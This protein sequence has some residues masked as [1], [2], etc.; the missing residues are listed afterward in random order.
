[1]KKY[2]SVV[3][4]LVLVAISTVGY[5]AEQEKRVLDKEKVVEFGL[6]KSKKL[7]KL[8]QDIKIAQAKL[9]GAESA[10][11]PN[12]DLNTNYTR[13]GEAPKTNGSKDKFSFK[14]NLQQPIFLGGQLRSG[15]Q[16]ARNQLQVAKLEFQEKKQEVKYQVVEQ[17]YNVLKMKKM[18]QVSQQQL[19]R[20]DHYLEV[21]ETNQE[22]GVATKTD[23][24]QAKVNQT[25]A[26]QS[27]LEAKNKLET[28]K[29]DLKNSLNLADEVRLE[30][31]DQLSWEPVKVTTDQAYKTALDNRIQFELLDLQ[32]KNLKLNLEQIEN[33]KKYPNLNLAANYEAQDKEFTIS[34]GDWNV[35]LKLSYNLFDG[36]QKKS[37]IKELTKEVNKFKTNQQQIKDQIKLQV[38][39]TVLD[40][41]EAKERINLNK[42]NLEKSQENLDQV[43]LKFEEGMVTSLQMLDAE[44]TLEQIKTDYYQAIYDYN[45]ALAKLNKILGKEVT[46]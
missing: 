11:Y 13:F 41:Q 17:Y 30:L 16:Q 35:M 38:K 34:D 36:G 45:M 2:M 26:Q 32:E 19:K 20:I 21:A 10:F 29:L 40:L 7:Q 4:V 5:A 1:M 39:Q 22:V 23:V 15:Y 25:Q 18:I 46:Q 9:E 43:K 8:R 37:K 31:S 12:L 33:K 44:T 14:L 6:Q 28:A 42:L 24:L 3:V 27:L